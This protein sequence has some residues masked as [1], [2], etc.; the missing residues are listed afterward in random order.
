MN[1]NEIRRASKEVQIGNIRIGGK[2]PIAIQTMTNTDTLDAEATVAQICAMEAAGADIVRITVPTLEAA[3]LRGLAPATA[4]EVDIIGDAAALCV[5]DY[6][7]LLTHSSLEFKNFVAGGALGSAFGSFAGKLLRT[8]PKVKAK[9]CIGC[10]VCYNICP[11]KAIVIKNKIAVIDKK[12]CIR[13]FCCQEFCPKGAMKVHR[14]AIARLLVKD[15][16][17]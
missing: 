4:Q 5:D 17:K 9:E 3:Y 15:S 6:K 13:C 1:Y 14:T 8:R 2:N 11:A 12:A 7:K 10:G 16:K